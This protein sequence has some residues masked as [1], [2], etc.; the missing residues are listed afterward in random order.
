MQLCFS[1]GVHVM[2][3]YARAAAAQ[4]RSTADE[5]HDDAIQTAVD[6]LGGLVTR[7]REVL[8]QAARPRSEA[9]TQALAFI[10][11]E[12]GDMGFVPCPVCAGRIR[13][14]RSLNGERPWLH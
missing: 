7:G 2:L 8:A 1:K 3:A 6:A 13:W 12:P 5:E 14:I 4:I 11:E 9:V 10:A